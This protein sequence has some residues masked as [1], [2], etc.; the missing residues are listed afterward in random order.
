MQKYRIKFF[1]P[2][3]MVPTGQLT[4]VIEYEELIIE[5]RELSIRE[6]CYTFWVGEWGETNRL[7]CAY[8]IAS[9]VIESIFE[10]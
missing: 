1:S 4:L 8:P 5:C 3:I 9:T 10:N 2:K 6:N 7:L